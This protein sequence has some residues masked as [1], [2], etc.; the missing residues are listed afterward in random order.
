[1]QAWHYKAVL[2]VNPAILFVNLLP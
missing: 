1:M 2:F